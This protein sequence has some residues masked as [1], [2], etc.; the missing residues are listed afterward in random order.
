MICLSLRP[1]SVMILQ[2]RRAVTGTRSRSDKMCNFHAHFI[3]KSEGKK[4]INISG[5]V[6]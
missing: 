2:L 5:T 6:T 3:I 4:I 1:V